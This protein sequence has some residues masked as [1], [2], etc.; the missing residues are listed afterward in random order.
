MKRG[1]TWITLTCLMVA[2]LVLASCAKSTTSTPTSATTTTKTTTTTTTQTTTPST[3]TGTAPTTTTTSAA[4]GNWWDSLG[5]PQYGGT[6]I[7]RMNNDLAA[8]EPWSASGSTNIYDAWLEKPIADDWTLNPS[9]YN[10]KTNWRPPDFVKGD[11]MVSYEFTDPNTYVMHLRQGVHWQNLP[12]ANGREFVADDVVFHY[13]RLLGLGNGFTSPDPYY[14]IPSN[15]WANCLA[16]TST[17][18]YTVVMKWKMPNPEQILETIQGIGGENTIECPDAVKQWGILSD[19]HHAI[20]TGPF[21]LTDFVSGSSATLVKNPD[22]WNYDQRYPQNK[23]PYVDSLKFLIIPDNATALSAM[24]TGKLDVLNMQS[25]QIAQQMMNTNPEILQ[26]PTPQSTTS[27]IVPRNDK[28]P[29][30]DVRVRQALQMAINLQD[31]ATNYYAGTCLPN[32][33]SLTGPALT[34]WGFPYDQWPQDLKDQYAFNVPEAKT[35][36]AA[37]GVT[38]PFNTD[39]VVAASSD[40]TLL[41][42]VQ[43]DFTAIGVN[44]EIRT[45]DSASWLNF[46]RYGHK[47]DAL[48]EQLG[49]D[50]LGL[51]YEPFRQLGRFVTGNSANWAVVSDPKI[52]AWLVAA[53]AATNVDQV[54]Q[55]LKDENEYIAQQ[56]IAISLLDP[57]LYAFCQP[58]LKGYSGQSMSITGE[59]GAPLLCSFYASRF[60]IDQTL[61]KSLGH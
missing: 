58:W 52:D 21:I 20:G 39:I 59:V 48:A 23:L 42:I 53:G 8:W 12:P 46:V 3:T 56:H 34:G 55:I 24:R 44:M 26:I 29:Y 5:T 31:I 60:W 61:K 50:P 51:T 37:A 43:S 22:Y 28:A 19:W 57:M 2:S 40:L 33:C 47:H 13:D 27:A 38:T 16:V 17:D 7:L 18:N 1:T 54:K 10:Y 9:V 14:G 4:T 35:L 25:T 32:P 36:L 41:Q 11:L 15:A 6:M 45:M 49:G 30:N